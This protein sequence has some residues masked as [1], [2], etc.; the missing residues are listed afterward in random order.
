MGGAYLG[1]NRIF[2]GSG[3]DTIAV[4]YGDRAFGGSGDDEFDATEARNYRISGGAGND[5][6]FL[7]VGGRALGGDGDDTFNVLEGG[8]NLLSGGAG[9]DIFNILTDSAAVLTTPNTIV[10]FTIGT[11]TLG[12][13]N[14]GAG[15]DFSDLD[16]NTGNEI[17][18]AGNTIAILVGVQTNTLS[19]NSFSFS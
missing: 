3:S 2:T 14:Q 7:G 1:S 15:F 17:K 4:A 11:D 5:E 13:L 16:L 12:I 10:D 19:A 6:F 18:V 8:G 9:S